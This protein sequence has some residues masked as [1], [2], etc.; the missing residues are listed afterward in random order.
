MVELYGDNIT[1]VPTD[2]KDVNSLSINRTGNLKSILPIEISS[3][4][5]WRTSLI[6]LPKGLKVE[7]LFLQ[8]SPFIE[9]LSNLGD[10]DFRLLVLNGLGINSI[11]DVKP[12]SLYL[13]GDLP[14]LKTLP[15]DFEVGLTLEISGDTAIRELPKGLKIGW[16][17]SL[18]CEPQFDKLPDDLEVSQE[19]KVFDIPTY[20]PE[21]LKDKIKV[22]ERTKN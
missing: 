9:S 8:E 4:H 19:I 12:R 13:Q 7:T 22:I 2:L 21:H 11:G 6:E 15:T 16:N 1:E 5:L 18:L 10:A 17:L 14:N 20:C 3:L